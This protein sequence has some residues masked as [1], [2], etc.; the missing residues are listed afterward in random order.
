MFT[1]V[2]IFSM[3]SEFRVT[4]WSRSCDGLL[5][6]DSEANMLPSILESYK[7]AEGSNGPAK[8]RIAARRNFD[9]FRVNGADE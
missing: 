4:P 3:N 7:S 6:V 5:S 1:T 9:F 2:I 8:D